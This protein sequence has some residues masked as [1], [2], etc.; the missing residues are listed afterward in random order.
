MTL[1]KLRRVHCSKAPNGRNPG[2]AARALRFGV[3]NTLEGLAPLTEKVIGCAIAVHRT[4]GPGLLESVFRDCLLIELTDAHVL[5]ATEQRV[6]IEY[7]GRRIASHLKVDLLIEQR[8]IVEI[9][10]L[11]V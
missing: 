7:G 1:Q 11:S 9:K 3:E 10:R 5:V 4:L 6:P 8:L 2:G